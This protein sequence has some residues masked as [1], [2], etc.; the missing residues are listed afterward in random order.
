MTTLRVHEIALQVVTE[1]APLMPKIARLDRNLAQ[2]LR[3]AATSIVL[4]IAEGE[5]SDPGTRR[6]RF[7]T[8]AGSASETRAAIRLAAAW[9]YLQPNQV[10]SCLAGLDRVLAM[11][12]KLTH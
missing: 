7:H 6:A 12:W 2:Q 10:E 4:N 3:R 5:H 11:L 9:R 1:L 8:A